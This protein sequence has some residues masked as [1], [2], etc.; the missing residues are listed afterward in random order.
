[1]GTVK[2]YEAADPRLGRHVVHDDKSWGYRVQMSR[3]VLHSVDHE[4]HNPIWDQGNVGSC[5][6][7]AL[8]GVL[9]TGPF[10]VKGRDF[11]EADA[12]AVYHEETQIDD[13][14][15]P[16]RWPPDDTGSAGIYSMKVARKHKWIKLY[17]HI[18]ATE[19]VLGTLVTRP[20]SVGIPWYQE[21][22]DP[23]KD[24]FVEAKG[25]IVGG[26]QICVD[27]IN[28]DKEWV[29]FA[30]SWGN[31]WGREGWGFMSFDTLDTLLKNYGDAV[32]P[33]VV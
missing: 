1:M 25:R 30:N 14:Q 8:L 11:T 16:G 7:N 21:M 22:F 4:R 20:V 3:P 6:A 23:D 24:G 17:R 28:P 13:R 33:A 29:R 31:D 12:Q 15:I 2:I 26:H 18:F 19:T 9:V 10:Y 27:G 32:V 5:T